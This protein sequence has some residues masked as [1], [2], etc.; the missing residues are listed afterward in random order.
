MFSIPG[1][2][3][4]LS[5]E[6]LL[7]YSEQDMLKNATMYKF[8]FQEQC[9]QVIIMLYL[10]KYKSIMFYC[11][12]KDFSH[13]KLCNLSKNNFGQSLR[14]HH[15]YSNNEFQSALQRSYLY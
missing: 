5:H 13:Q 8:P 7:L 6:S 14:K 12:T 2:H 10:E 1:P 11:N 3:P 4:C 9:F 15:V